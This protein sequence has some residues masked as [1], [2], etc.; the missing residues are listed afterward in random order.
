MMDIAG[1]MRDEFKYQLDLLENVTDD[2]FTIRPQTSKLLR[3][4]SQIQ[5]DTSINRFKFGELVL[6]DRKYN[7]SSHANFCCVCGRGAWFGKLMK[8]GNCQSMI[9][10]NA[11]CSKI[12]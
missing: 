11:E 9:H 4:F 12:L 7:P 10:V 2:A 1:R 8:C 3:N 6:L 5:Y